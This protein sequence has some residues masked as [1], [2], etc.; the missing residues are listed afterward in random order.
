MFY[1][2]IATLL[3]VLTAILAEKQGRNKWLALFLGFIFGIFALL[4]YLI[5]GESDEKKIERLTEAQ[6]RANNS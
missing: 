4:G 6:R 1:V 2:L 5:A 3:A